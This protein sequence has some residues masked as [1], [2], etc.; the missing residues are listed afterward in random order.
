MKIDERFLY[1]PRYFEMLLSS[2]GLLSGDERKERIL[3]IAK[4]NIWL[5]ARCVNTCVYE[6]DSVID[7]IIH[8]AIFIY[9]KFKDIHAIAALLELREYGELSVM[10]DLMIK[11]STYNNL[12]KDIW[13]LLQNDERSISKAFAVFAD[14]I[15]KE[16]AASLFGCLS[17]LGYAMDSSAYNSVL[18]NIDNPDEIKLLV[19]KMTVSGVEADAETF[20]HLIRKSNSFEDAWYYF[21]KFKAIVDYNLNEDLVSGTYN[22][23][24]RIARSL[25]DINDLKNDYLQHCPEVER[26]QSI[27]LAC[28][29]RS[30]EI[31]TTYEE[32]KYYFDEFKE[33]Y[34][35]TFY[36]ERLS[37]GKKNLTSK[38]KRAIVN[39][40][41]IFMRRIERE[42]LEFEEVEAILLW[43]FKQYSIFRNK[44]KKESVGI[45]NDFISNII[46][47]S[48]DYTKGMRLVI[49]L[50]DADLWI[51]QSCYTE[52]F[53]CSQTKEDVDNIKAVIGVIPLNPKNVLKILQNCSDSVLDYILDYFKEID[54][55]LNI[56]HFN[57]IIKRMPFEKAFDVINLMKT[58]G[59]IPDKF[60]IQ[61]M[62][63]KWNSVKDLSKVLQLATSYSISADERSAQAIARQ[64]RIKNLSSELIDYSIENRES[65]NCRLGESWVNAV[66][67][68]S[69]FLLREFY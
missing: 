4:K 21:E 66:L 54:Y 47:K 55:S 17:E 7:W 58:S 65:A 28:Y 50:L 30:I 15:D 61:P 10:L 41:N 32:A 23:M 8:R 56:Y 34:V 9:S 36:G 13:L 63:R 20:F 22:T 62:L 68:A 59:M 29:A 18:A 31:S 5:A 26:Q 44:H 53:I 39:I 1:D 40:V 52:L 46:S 19:N 49:S 69:N 57:A 12:H 27:T 51:S 45:F 37:K 64:A 14:Y 16:L 33:Y 11:N 24:I 2:A 38:Q 3:T 35:P 67:D 6:D 60:T 42:N 43:I 25:Q 48:K